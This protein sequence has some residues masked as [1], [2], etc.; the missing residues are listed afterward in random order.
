MVRLGTLPVVLVAFMVVLVVVIR[1]R[2]MLVRLLLVAFF[3]VVCV[4][5][6]V[7]LW[8]GA[9]EVE[10]S[11]AITIR[12]RLPNIMSCRAGAGQGRGEG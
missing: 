8:A 2:V 5:D 3:K 9:P 4:G 11:D 1:L 6:V 10:Q 12:I 7:H